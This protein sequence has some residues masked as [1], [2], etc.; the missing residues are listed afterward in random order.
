MRR[1]QYSSQESKAAFAIRTA[2][3]TLMPIMAWNDL[4]STSETSMGA[5]WVAMNH[6]VP[7]AYIVTELLGPLY[8]NHTPHFW[9]GG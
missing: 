5:E 8:E 6:C 9:G 2:S 7:S 1:I 4:A 3:K